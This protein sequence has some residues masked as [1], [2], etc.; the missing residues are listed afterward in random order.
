MG[1]TEVLEMAKDIPS[2]SSRASTPP[3]GSHRPHSLLSPWDLLVIDYSN[4]GQIAPKESS[5][6]R[7][8][9]LYNTNRLADQD[10]FPVNYLG[11][12]I[13]N[14]K[15]EAKMWESEAWGPTNGLSLF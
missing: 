4:S 12:L 11:L 1:S 13:R 2:P 8:F 9:H 10:R 7:I 5:C 14:K 6:V 15:S 3:V